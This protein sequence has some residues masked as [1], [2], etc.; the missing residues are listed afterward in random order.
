MNLE[1]VAPAQSARTVPALLVMFICNHCPFVKHVRS[2]LAQL[3]K[4]YQ[5]RGVAVED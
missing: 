4:D 2:G 3:A 1:L 5:P